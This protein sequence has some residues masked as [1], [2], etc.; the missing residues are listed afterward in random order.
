MELLYK[1]EGIYAQL[2][3]M[4]LDDEAFQDTLDSIDFQD[5]LEKN[6]E[7]F[8]KMLR[9]SE[10]K[11][12]MLKAERDF[13]DE[14]TKSEEVKAEKYKDAIHRALRLSKTKKIDAGPFTISLKKSR[15][16]EILDLKMIPMEYLREKNE[17]KP[18]KNEMAK[19]LKSGEKIPGAELVET[20]SVQVK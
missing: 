10:A 13:Y 1:L 14:K 12:S 8:V 3:A 11:S 5:N 20:E 2:E 9:N 4:E 15:R 7:Y 17:L 16:V 6:I 18:M 19:I